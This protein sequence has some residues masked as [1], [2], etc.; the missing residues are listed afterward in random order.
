MIRRRDFITL[1]GSAA[2]AWPLAA[3]AQQP[4]MPVVGLLNNGS[5]L[6]GTMYAAFRL[7]LKDT[8]FTEG[9]NVVV[10]SRLANDQYDRLPALA[11]DLIGRRARVIAAVGAAAAVAAKA[12]TATIP[13]VFFMGEDPVGLGL[14]PRL[15]QPDGNVTG[16]AT[17]SSAVIAKRLELLREL[18]SKATV[19]AVLINP[20][21]PNAEATTR[22]AQEAGRTLGQP[23]HVLTAGSE[24]DFEK[25]FASIVQLQAGALLIAPD[26]LFVSQAARLATLAVRY[27]IPA[28]H[29][30][31]AFPRAGGLVSYGASQS[32][33]LRQV[34]VYAG[35]ILKGEKPGDLPVMQPTKFELVI[36]LKTAKALG[37]TVPPSLLAVAD[38][39]I[40]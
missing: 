19:C 38:E 28:S 15:N 24:S 2:T 34:G 31:S 36:N 30:R 25:V 17:L 21:N 10:E 40:E 13:V 6:G 20:T 5:D 37:L 11:A 4:A 12:A 14:V 26:G 16:V 23:V 8:G 9:Q 29:E 3:R 27:G 22:D 7:G 32:E 39:V 1:L 35:R 33:A 18:V